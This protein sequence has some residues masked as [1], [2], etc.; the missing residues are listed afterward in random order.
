MCDVSALTRLVPLRALL[1]QRAWASPE[2]LLE[3]L[4]AYGRTHGAW[5]DAHGYAEGSLARLTEAAGGARPVLPSVKLHPDFLCGL[6]FNCAREELAF[7]GRHGLRVQ[8]VAID[9]PL[10]PGEL[11]VFDNLAVAHGRCGTRRPGELRQR[12]YGYKH[13]SA[14]A[15]RQLRDRVLSAFYPGAHQESTA[16]AT[17][18][19]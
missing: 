12:V 6:E 18:R 9:V 8:E 1:E 2:E 19:R 16:L 3:R 7:F 15:Q 14:T 4:A 17:S 13:M 11:L 10:Q 5:D